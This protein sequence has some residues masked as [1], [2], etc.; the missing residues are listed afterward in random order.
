MLSNTDLWV[1]VPLPPMQWKNGCDLGETVYICQDLVGVFQE[2]I[3][4][5]KSAHEYAV[6][7]F[8]ENGGQWAE[9]GK[10]IIEKDYQEIVQQSI[11][12]EHDMQD[13]YPTCL[14]TSASSFSATR[15][16][17]GIH[18]Y[19]N[20]NH[21]TVQIL[22]SRDYAKGFGK[23]KYGLT[24]DEGLLVVGSANYTHIFSQ[25]DG[26]HEWKE[27]L[28]FDQS[29]ERYALSDRTLIAL[30]DKEAYS[31]SIADCTPEMSIPYL[32][33]ENNLNC[34]E[35]TVS[36]TFSNDVDDDWYNE[37]FC[38]FWDWELEI[39]T[40]EF[41]E[42]DST[43]IKSFVS[44]DGDSGFGHANNNTICLTQG[45]YHIVFRHNWDCGRNTT[46]NISF[47]FPDWR[48]K[49]FEINGVLE[50]TGFEWTELHFD[51][52]RTTLRVPTLSPTT[53][54]PTWV[55]TTTPRPTYWPDWPTYYSNYSTQIPTAS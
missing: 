3:N 54:Y 20:F 23:W 15:T 47:D 13:K 12:A 8:K 52:P 55:P 6:Y 46:Y 21:K 24:M 28:K 40:S 2:C 36:F 49:D 14:S 17:N 29:Y 48:D 41:L 5:N 4:P 22:K 39:L 37:H 9:I 1:E 16:K 33:S 51:I 11:L 27:V 18:I 44:H 50:W 34:S 42:V 26:S 43:V 25:E 35:M 7:F 19:D 31:M 10:Q 38:S 32:P 45:W 30:N 53:Q